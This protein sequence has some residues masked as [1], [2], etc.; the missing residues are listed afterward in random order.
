DHELAGPKR[1]T[2]TLER[3]RQ[4]ALGVELVDHAPGEADGTLGELAVGLA[5]RL[6]RDVALTERE[7]ENVGQRPLALAHPHED[8]ADD[9]REAG[10]DEERREEAARAHRDH[11]DRSG[12][13]S[14]FVSGTRIARAARGVGGAAAAR[15]G[16][17]KAL[18]G[19]SMPASPSLSR[20]FG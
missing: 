17:W 13:A 16:A 20:N 10:A 12:A 18:A 5:D 8:A 2:G 3:R 1:E 19:T 7:V 6:D 15:R 14:C 4:R 11:R 9:E